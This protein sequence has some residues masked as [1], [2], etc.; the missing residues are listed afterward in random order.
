MCMCNIIIDKD[1]GSVKHCKKGK[2]N[3]DCGIKNLPPLYAIPGPVFWI[4]EDDIPLFLKH[5][6][7]VSFIACGVCYYVIFWQCGNA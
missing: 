2:L 1:V 3:Y 6:T 7:T 4:E 5:L